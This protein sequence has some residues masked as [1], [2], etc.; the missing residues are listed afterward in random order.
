MIDDMHGWYHD[1]APRTEAYGWTPAI[2]IYDSVA[3]IEKRK[4]PPPRHIKV[5]VPRPGA[6]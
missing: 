1:E 4:V 2:H 5:G 3:V 6:G